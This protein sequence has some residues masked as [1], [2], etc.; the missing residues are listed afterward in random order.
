[1]V[2]AVTMATP[3]NS[4]MNSSPLPPSTSNDC[5]PSA[6]SRPNHM[7]TCRTLRSMPNS[8]RADTP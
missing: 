3:V 1:M 6:T 7:D 2:V 5:A 8:H 4:E